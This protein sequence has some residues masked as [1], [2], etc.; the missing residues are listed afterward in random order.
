MNNPL[1]DM[2]F[3]NELNNYRQREIYARITRLT[4]DELPIEYIEGRVTTGNVTVDGNSAL[5]RTCNVTMTLKN[6]HEINNFNWTFKQ[7][8]KLEVGLKNFINPIYDDIIWFPQGIFILTS[9]DMN[10]TTNNYTI[11]INGKDKMCKLNGDVG[12]NITASSYDFGTIEDVDA[13]GHIV[14]TKLLLKD[15][16]R[17]LLIQ[18]GELPDNIIINDLDEA[19]LELME[20]RCETQPLFLFRQCETGIVD[21]ITLNTEH[22]IVLTDG[23][24]ST[25]GNNEDIIYIKSSELYGGAQPETA[26]IVTLN[27]TSNIQYQIMKFDYGDLAGYRLTD[28]TYA[29]ELK[30]NVGETAMS[31]LDKIKNM[32]G[33]FEYFYN[34]DGKFVFQKKRTYISTPWNANETTEEDYINQAVNDSFP[35]INLMDAKLTTSFANRPNLLNL[36]NDFSV[37][38]T[39]KSISGSDIPIHMRYAIDKKPSEYTS[40]RDNITYKV[41]VDC[42]WRELIYQMALD[43]YKHHTEEDFH[44]RVIAANPHL[45]PSGRTGYEQYY[46]DIQGFWRQLYDPNPDLIAEEI[47]AH[48]IQSIF[49]QDYSSLLVSDAY[50]VVD[51]KTRETLLE[52]LIKNDKLDI[53]I[54]DLYVIMDNTIVNADGSSA[55][56]KTFYPFIGSSYCC[57]TSGKTYYYPNNNTFKSSADVAVLNTQYLKSLYEDIGNGTKKLV[58]DL[59]LKQFLESHTEVKLWTKSKENVSWDNLDVECQQVYH[60][61]LVSNQDF[62]QYL[63]NW[64]ISDNFGTLSSKRETV[65]KITYMQMIANHDYDSRTHFHKDVIEN[66]ESLIFW[67][68]F[69]DAEGSELF[70]N[71]CVASVG[72][73]TKAINDSNVKSMYYRDVPDIIFVQSLA[74]IEYDKKPGYTYIQIPAAYQTLFNISG[75]GKSAKERIDELLQE[76]SYC[77]EA[78]TIAAVP[79]YHL[80]PN[81][82]IL[83]RDDT[84]NVNGEYIINKVTVPLAYN[85]T[86]SLT[87]NKVVSNIM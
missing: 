52:Q 72:D 80:E 28:L 56:K 59:R 77:I 30:A 5:R 21:N 10:Q 23:R 34:L 25:V 8:F 33:N 13:D 27:H 36:K 87:A 49:N 22:P 14:Y 74:D 60:G 69:L 1:M 51:N 61:G 45:A 3:L 17:E 19:G 9:C 50:I 40:I 84:S 75:R 12:G 70:D 26:T 4:Q 18:F 47:E 54:N 20:Y 24:E 7:K 62:I 15:I 41:S 66:P 31:V 78:T 37:W 68:D 65:E 55:I 39:Y 11:T 43:Y 38:G 46:T 76:H 85:G 53:D 83:V 82:R 86:M 2:E 35:V 81:T 64:A 58:I 16:I 71:Y 79:I 57:L 44:Q 32:L 42:D 73:R 48:K 29:G 63:Y 6:Q 67:L